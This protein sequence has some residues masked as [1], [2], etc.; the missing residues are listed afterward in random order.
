LRAI[1]PAVNFAHRADNITLPQFQGICTHYR[2]DVNRYSDDLYIHHQVPFPSAFHSASALRKAEF[3]AGRIAAEQAFIGLGLEPQTVPI[4]NLREPLWPN[5]VLGSISHHNGHAYCLMMP[6]PAN[7]HSPVSLGID[8]ESLIGNDDV[9]TMGLNIMSSSEISLTSAY[10]ER[11]EFA[12][13]LI[14]SAKESLFKALYPA[15]GRYFDF[16]DIRLSSIN[17]D[18]NSVAFTL[19]N[20]L[21]MHLLRGYTVTVHWQQFANAVV[22]WVYPE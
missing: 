7:L 14:F 21:S 16:L 8:I 18:D 10:F 12:L 5:S 9:D 20:D 6:R 13:T 4:G 19:R 11:P 17:L 15:V 22:T 2:F 3:I 1:T